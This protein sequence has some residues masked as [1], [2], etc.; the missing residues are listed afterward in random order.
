MERRYPRKFLWRSIKNFNSE[1]TKRQIQ[2]EAIVY[3][4]ELQTKKSLVVPGTQKPCDSN[5]GV[6]CDET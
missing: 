3:I 2:T 6:S 1:T 5:K 4:N